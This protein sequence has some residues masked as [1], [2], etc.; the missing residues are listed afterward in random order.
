MGLLAG[1]KRTRSIVACDVEISWEHVRRARCIKLLHVE[2]YGPS[3]IRKK[4]TGGTEKADGFGVL[5]YVSV[6]A[7]S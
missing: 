2:Y 5:G 1:T 3:K 4:E 6:G 7:W